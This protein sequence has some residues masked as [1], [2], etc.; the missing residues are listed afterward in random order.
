MHWKRRGPRL[1]VGATTA[2][3]AVASMTIA[4]PAK[5]PPREPTRSDVEKERVNTA[6][7]NKKPP[8][9]HIAKVGKSRCTSY[10]YER[11][12]KNLL[13][14]RMYNYR[15]EIDWCFRRGRITSA[16]YNTIPTTG[17]LFWKYFSKDEKIKRTGG[18]KRGFYKVYAQG[19]FAACGPSSIGC[20]QDKYPWV[21]IRVGGDG[22]VDANGGG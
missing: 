10:W 18:R 19:H 5:M 1:A 4:A 15:L 7:A 8:G 22:S 14:K 12:G 3:V 6:G 21:Q 9:T 11:Y 2:L 16:S 20:V 13:G 17:G